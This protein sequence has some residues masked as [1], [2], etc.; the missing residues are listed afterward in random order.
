MR[1]ANSYNRKQT[2]KLNKEDLEDL[3]QDTPYNTYR[4]NGL[5]P[6]P[7][8]LVGQASLSAAV[9]PDTGSEIYFVATGRNDGSHYFSTTLQ[10]HNSAVARYLIELESTN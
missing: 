7:I 3:V 9:N 1:F 8:A 10:E 2:K 4:R 5:P 6:S